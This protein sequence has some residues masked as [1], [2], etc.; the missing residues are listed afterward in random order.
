[1]PEDSRSACIGGLN[2]LVLSAESLVLI[3]VLASLQTESNPFPPFISSSFPFFPYS[4]A[5]CPS[6][7]SYS[8]VVQ[9][10]SCLVFFPP[11]NVFV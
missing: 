9:D 11:C 3:M 8:H 5:S 7:V 4:T 2:T 1:M 6:S 10:F